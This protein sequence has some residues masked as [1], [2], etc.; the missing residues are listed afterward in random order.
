VL[1]HVLLRIGLIAAGLGA[2]AAALGLWES[3]DMVR[4]PLSV[5]L[6]LGLTL[7]G[8]LLLG[9]A[10]IARIPPRAVWL[11]PAALVCV[12][13]AHAQRSHIGGLMNTTRPTADVYL[14]TDY[15]VHLLAQGVNPYTHDYSDLFTVY[16]ASQRMAT[17]T[18][19]GDF[20]SSVSYP[21]L[22]IVLSAALSAVGLGAQDTAFS[23]FLVG[24]AVLL[25]VGVPR[26]FRPVALLPL[27]IEPRYV[28]YTLGGVNDIVWVFFVSLAIVLWRRGG[29]KSAVAFGLACAYKQQP[30]FFAPFLLLTLWAERADEPVRARVRAAAVYTGV[31]VAVFA[32]VNAPFALNAP[33]AWLRGLLVPFTTPMITLGQGWSSLTTQG[34]ILIPRAVSTVQFAVVYL[35]L[36]AVYARHPRAL[37][38]FLWLAPSVAFV[39]GPRSLNSYWYFNLFP[40][41]LA[42]FRAGWVLDAMRIT[43]AYGSRW[44]GS[45]LVAGAAAAVVVASTAAFAVRENPLAL[46]VERPI[47][48]EGDRVHD[49]VVTLHNQADRALEPRFSVQMAGLQPL[50]WEIVT[51]PPALASGE[52]ARYRVRALTPD[53]TFTMATGAQVVVT[54]RTDPAL[55][56]SVVL[57]GT[58]SYLYPDGVPNDAYEFWPVG[59]RAPAFWGIIAT[60]DFGGEPVSAIAGEPYGRG[61]RLTLAAPGTDTYNSLMLDN[62]LLFP[63]GDLTAWVHPPADANHAADG[64]ARVYGLELNETFTGHRVWVLFGEADADTPMTGTIAAGGDTIAYARVAAPRGV[65]SEV[66]VNARALFAAVGFTP[67]PAAPLATRFDSIHAPRQMLNLRLLAA[68]RTAADPGAQGA[69]TADFGPISNPAVFADPAPLIARSLEQPAERFTSRGDLLRETGETVRAA[70]YYRLALEA[71]PAYAAA[72]YG[73]G[74]T[75]RAAGA[76]ADA[77]AAFTRALTEGYARR[78]A[79]LIEQAWALYQ[80]GRA[81]DAL[82]IAADAVRL[83]DAEPFFYDRYAQ[84]D[85]L[86]RYGFILLAEARY[87]LAEAVFAAAREQDPRSASAHLG[88]GLAVLMAGRTADARASSDALAALN[89]AAALGWNDVPGTTG[90][91]LGAADACARLADLTALSGDPAWAAAPCAVQPGAGWALPG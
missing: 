27:L 74:E 9:C 69:F 45:A 28:F 30:W 35:A 23:F 4:A 85:T 75:A 81:A 59:G 89:T 37:W 61:V 44:R 7:F 76:W 65:W 2:W 70:V 33:E 19:D 80:Q 83:L 24:T 32:L 49:L 15:A 51:G 67:A 14:L 31:A 88:T 11:I 25:W 5:W 50:Y 91:A 38:P 62:W 43:G 87:P 16:R 1:A 55:R 34:V 86:A 48:V 84:A 21:A 36:L 46:T 29:W 18:L 60:P 47:A 13:G 56:A 6:G 82:P 77:E 3:G 12:S 17:P 58:R 40:A 20:V 41:M 66:R 72:H 68:A 26:A 10:L 52:T 79:A 63:E 71:D 22:S 64:F 39:F 57:A 90:A 53:R 73:L 54:D 42:L 78:S 8:C